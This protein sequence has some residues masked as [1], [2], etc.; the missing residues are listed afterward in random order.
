[1]SPQRTGTTFLTVVIAAVLAVG[2]TPAHASISL[3]HVVSAIPAPFTPHVIDTNGVNDEVR[4][5]QQVGNVM[6]AGGLIGNVQDSGRTSTIPRNNIF[7]FNATTGAVGAFA[8]DF[9]GGVWAIVP[10]P[11]GSL[12]IG[13]QFTTVNG[14]ARR[15]LAKLNSSGTLDET[16][17]PVGMGTAGGVTDAKLVNGRLIVAGTFPKRLM[18]LNPTNGTDTGY[19]NLGITGTV[20]TNA[21][22]TRIYRFATNPAGTKLVAIGNFTSVGGQPRRQAF[23]ADLGATAGTVSGFYDLN[24]NKQCAAS[25][26]PVYLRDVDF[27]PDGATFGIAGTGY[28]PQAGDLGKSVCDAAALYSVGNTK[29]LWINYTGGDT[30]HSIALTGDIV[31]VGGHQRWLDNPQGNNNPGPGAQTQYGVGAIKASTG[32]AADVGWNPGK[33][34]GVGAKE[35]YVTP[36]GLWVGSDGRVFAGKIHDSLAFCPIN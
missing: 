3:P 23:M 19:L 17:K 14:V 13:G 35:L 4:V 5:F 16:W 22:S 34:R 7:S 10:L 20:A 21:G 2:L 33:T 24:W 11:D 26:L 28:I 1:M 18:A 30:L 31:Y 29:P 36:A 8:P 27:S 15:G 9:D 25:S 6:Y 12:V 32:K